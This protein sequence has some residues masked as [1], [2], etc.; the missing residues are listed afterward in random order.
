MADVRWL[1][2]REMA[3]ALAIAPKS[4]QRLAQR[5][6]W[7]RQPGNDGQVRIGVPVDR[8]PPAID[9][10][11]PTDPP[12]VAPSSS[13]ASPPTVDNQVHLAL[14]RLEVEVAG[15]REL[16][17]AE[18]ARAEAEGRRADGEARRADAAEAD[19]DAWRT[20]ADRPWWRRAFRVA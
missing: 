13:P 18:R 17:A 10:I 15:L 5:R 9:A 2:Y 8:L 16:V 20:I 14:A 12:T 11:E 6:K 19:R 3:A 4:A 7:P 1:S